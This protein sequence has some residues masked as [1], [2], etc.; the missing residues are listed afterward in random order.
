LHTE[1][2]KDAIDYAAYPDY[3]TAYVPAP[4]QVVQL[5]QSNYF[6]ANLLELDLPKERNYASLDSF[7][8]Y[9][10]LRGKAILRDDQ[11]NA[12][13][14]QQ[15]QTVLLAAETRNVTIIPEP[16]TKLLETYIG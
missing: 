6:T 7:V 8:I 12:I 1:L 4:N 13:T 3:R 10:C 5:V 15:G 16:Q 11:N 14:I 2:A 9:I